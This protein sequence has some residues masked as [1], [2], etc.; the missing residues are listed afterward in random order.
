MPSIDST[1][2]TH[3]FDVTD[4]VNSTEVAFIQG[5]ATG[6]IHRDYKD[7]QGYL[8]AVA[9]EGPS[10]LQI[11]DL[12]SLPNSAP[13]V[14]DIVIHQIAVIGLNTKKESEH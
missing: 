11:I 7:Y 9:D 2:G 5:A 12:N 10:T 6:V 4:P 14:Y 1:L 8:Y 3:I 13:L